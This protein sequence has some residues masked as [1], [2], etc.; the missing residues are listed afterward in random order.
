MKSKRSIMG[1]AALLVL[2]FHFYIPVFNNTA[3]TFIYRS[4]YIGVDLFFF[5]SATSI[6]KKD[7]IDYLPFI[8]NRFKAVYIP[9]VIF[10]VIAFVYKKWPLKRLILTVCGADFLKNGGGSFLWFAPGIMLFYLAAPAVCRAGKKYGLK[11]LPVFLLLWFALCCILQYGFN[12]KKIFILLNRI[13]IFLAGIFYEDFCRKRPEKYRIPIDAFLLAAG[14]FLVSKF[15]ITVR[16][17]KPVSDFYYIVSIPLI[18][19][20]AEIIEFISEKIKLVPLAFIGSFTFE[21][22]ALQMIFGYDIE[23]WLLKVSGNKLI[24]FSGVTVI[25]IVMSY[26]FYSLKKLVL[27]SNK[28]LRSVFK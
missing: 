1:Y 23:T 18:L 24:A 16:L 27:Y 8:A 15:G 13:P 9:F 21:I 17:N 2:L 20:V 12:Y 10:A 26:A 14:V 11:S 19:A 22:Y 7:R 4:A 3:E 28:Q 6:S 5:V 25:L